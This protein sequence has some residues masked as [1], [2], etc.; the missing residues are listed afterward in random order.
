MQSCTMR[1]LRA[2]RRCKEN[3]GKT[4]VLDAVRAVGGGYE[5]S[6]EDFGEA[7]TKT[8]IQ[9]SLSF[10]EEDLDLLRRRVL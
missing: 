3:T 10:T 5:I 6:P 9:V 1:S 8:R 2:G 4:T 7:G